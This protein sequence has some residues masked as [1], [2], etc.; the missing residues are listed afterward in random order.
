MIYIMCFMLSTIFI[1][2]GTKD[3]KINKILVS[4]G[5]IIPS[6]LAALRDCTV[7]SDVSYYVVPY[8]NRAVG[9]TT[10]LNYVKVS[11][12]DVG[13]LL[14]NYIISRFTNNIGWLFFICQFIVLIFVF[15]AILKF[16]ELLP[17]SI[18][19]AMLCYY[20]IFYNL[21]LSTVRQSIAIAISFYCITIFMHCH[22][23]DLRIMIKISALL[24]LAMS[25]HATTVFAC[26]IL[27]IIYV[28][29]RFKLNTS[30]T[31]LVTVILS[32]IFG[33]FSNTFIRLAS[34]FAGLFSTK[35]ENWAYTGVNRGGLSGYFTII[36][37]GVICL[38]VNI[39]IEKS[40]KD[41]KQIM[42]NRCLIIL[43]TLYVGMMLFMS[44]ITFIPRL[45]YYI[46]IMWCI[47][48]S[49]I[50]IFFKKNKINQY[51]SMSLIVLILLVYWIYFYAIGG[52]HG[53]LP[54]TF[55]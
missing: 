2:Y 49:Q 44:H 30:L 5:L 20:L 12:S 3:N 36:I 28:Y 40:I 23:I 43:N 21:T 47:I 19:S 29:Q 10:F 41:G 37:V 50:S 9:N 53:T 8:F 46:Q 25:F 39:F 24:L 52:V 15:L 33:F 42:I 1:K 16:S 34:Q 27:I 22:K 48:F 17:V 26:L 14:L 13:Y 6:I 4:C 35:Y 38:V 55:R 45:M 54:Y 31:I 11:K 18:S 32:A 7:G 51:G